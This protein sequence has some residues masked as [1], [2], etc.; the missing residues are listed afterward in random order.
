M[1]RITSSK[2]SARVV[3]LRLAKLRRLNSRVVVARETS[4]GNDE[5][6]QTVRALQ[7]LLLDS[8]NNHVEEIEKRKSLKEAHVYCKVNALS[9]QLSGPLIERYMQKA[10][11][12]SKINASR[13]AGDL[14]LNEVSYELKISNG[15]KSNNKFNYVQLRMNHACRY[16]FTAYYLDNS[17]VASMGELF[18]FRLTKDALKAL[19]VE[20]GAYAHG[21]KRVLGEISIEDL[22][23]KDNTK[24][25]AL[26]PSYGDA[27]WR[28]LMLFR[29][30]EE[31]LFSAHPPSE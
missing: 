20:H 2:A 21:T 3:L 28:D 16:I 12:M 9:G 6:T 18:V 10:F 25:Y 19:L 4:S 26:R 13:C 27:C 15:G 5:T 1:T 24:E 11:G 29:V 7:R 8:S 17:N 23:R 30:P 14:M 31:L 22:N